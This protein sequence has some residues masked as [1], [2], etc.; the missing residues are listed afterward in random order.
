[1]SQLLSPAK[2]AGLELKNRLVMAPMCMYEVHEQDGRVTPFHMVHYGAR[3]LGNVG[4]IILEATA[5]SPEGR[6]TN[7]DLGIWNDE[8]TSGLKDLVADLHRFGSKVGIQLAHAGRKAEDAE[9]PLAPSAKPFSAAYACPKEMSLEDIKAVQ[10]QFVAAARRAQRVGFDMVELHAAH[11]YLI[12]QFLSPLTNDRK[13][14][15]GGN[16]KNRFRFL[17]ELLESTKEVFEGAIW[18][19]LSVR[20]Y[21]P[22]ENS[23]E[24]WIQVSQWLEE[25]GVSCIDISTGG[26]VNTKPDIPLVPG[27][28]VPYA[29]AIKEKLTGET[30]VAVVGLLDNPGLC[31]YLLQSQQADLILQGRALL[32]QANWLAD[33]AK[34]LGDRDYQPYNASYARGQL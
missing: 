28:Q 22:G 1:M 19:R 31:E 18:V 14:Q 13:D 33:A 4:L 15:Y 6:I 20:A 34:V 17:K 5:V 16:L 12:N 32:R 11:G 7:R 21:A 8:H 24:D 30:A 23:L 2:I 29:S 27:Y 9:C 26:V 25:L 10:V 3:A